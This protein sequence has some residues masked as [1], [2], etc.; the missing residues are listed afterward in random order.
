MNDID[1]SIQSFHLP[2]ALAER[3]PPVGASQK[4]VRTRHT[5]LAATASEMEDK[6]YEGLTI[7]G[8]VARAQMARGTFYIYFSNRSDAAMAVKRAFD[9][10][11]RQRRP[12][13]SGNLT[14]AQT[15]YRMNRFYV[16]CYARNARIIAGHTALMRERPELAHSRDFINHR[17][18]KIV[19][20]DISRRCGLPPAISQDSKAI[21]A[22]RAVIAMADELLR[23]IYVFQSPHLSKYAGSENDVA[24]AMTFVWYRAIFGSDPE[25]ISQCIPLIGAAGASSP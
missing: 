9:A 2:T 13:S 8:I 11:M 15:I 12:R 1:F 25:G 23:E 3:V 6:G 18:A 24:E 21:L 22:V 7:D 14:S 17:W 5:L 10:L 20:R 4:R 16:A 19:L